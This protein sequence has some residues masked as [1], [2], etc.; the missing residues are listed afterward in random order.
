VHLVNILRIFAFSLVLGHSNF[1]NTLFQWFCG[2]FGTPCSLPYTVLYYTGDK[3]VQQ[4][5]YLHKLWFESS[6]PNSPFLSVHVI[7]IQLQFILTIKERFIWTSYGLCIYNYSVIFKWKSSPFC[8][9]FL[10]ITMWGPL[11]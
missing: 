5:I 9:S 4:N 1:N 2:F 8:A 3:I 6:K 11:M 10:L 7:I